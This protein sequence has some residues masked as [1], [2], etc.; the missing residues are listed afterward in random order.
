MNS[1]KSYVEKIKSKYNIKSP[2]KSEY[3]TPDEYSENKESLYR[4]LGEYFPNNEI[5]DI[6]KDVENYRPL[7]IWDDPQIGSSAKCYMYDRRRRET[8][9]RSGIIIGHDSLA[10]YLKRSR[11]SLRVSRHHLILIK[12]TNS[13]IALRDIQEKLQ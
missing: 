7:E 13:Q 2:I 11:G 10:I 12:Y 8:L 9:C 4:K 6:S 3:I 5:E 1:A